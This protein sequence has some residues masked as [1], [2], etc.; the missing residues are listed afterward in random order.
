MWT[1]VV[2]MISMLGALILVAI[3]GSLD[4]GGMGLVFER[5]WNTSRIEAPK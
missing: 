1:D 3:K 2:Q 4:I 5:A